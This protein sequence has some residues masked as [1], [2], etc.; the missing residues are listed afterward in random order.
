[1]NSRNQWEITNCFV[2]EAQITPGRAHLGAKLP[3]NG[4]GQG[5]SRLGKHTTGWIFSEI[6][7]SAGNHEL[8]VNSQLKWTLAGPIWTQ[9]G[10]GQGQFELGI[11]SYFTTSSGFL[12]F[13]ENQPCQ[14]FSQ[15]RLPMA[16]PVGPCFGGQVELP[17]SNM[18][19]LFPNSIAESVKTRNPNEVMNLLC[20]PSSN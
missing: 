12:G 19:N 9:L 11:H 17:R 4:P 15:S 16:G 6:Q 13:T 7:E 3:P 18:D 5:A 2:L 1:M 14:M 20:F 10:P 8:A